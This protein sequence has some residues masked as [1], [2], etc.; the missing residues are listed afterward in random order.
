MDVRIE[1]NDDPNLVVEL[2]TTRGLT[3]TPAELARR[4][5]IQPEGHFVARGPDGAPAGVV[6]VTTWPSADGGFAWIFG[7]VVAPHARRAGV[8]RALLRHAMAHAERAGATVMALEAS[9]MG[10]GLYEKEGFRAVGESPRYR[11]KA[12]TEPA[13]PQGERRVAVYPISSCEIMDLWKYDAPRFGAVRVPWVASAMARFPERTFVAFDRGTGDIVGFV[14]SAERWMGPLV[15][16]DEHTAAWLLFAA[17]RAGAPP[18]AIAPPGH[19]RAGA[20]LESAGF[21]RDG[22]TFLRMVRGGPVPGRRET[23]WLASGWALG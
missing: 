12:G 14:A 17:E 19:P 7:M 23:Q 3:I 11:R 2:D 18:F 10:R 9:E 16:D 22:T 13:P 8:G 6:S 5:S 1:R 15:A 4:A 21:E 20:L